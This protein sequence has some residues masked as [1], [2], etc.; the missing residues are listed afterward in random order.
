MHSDGCKCIDIRFGHSPDNPQKFSESEETSHGVSLSLTNV[1]NGQPVTP[2]DGEDAPL[3]PNKR[4]LKHSRSRSRD[5]LGKFFGNG[6]S[7]TPRASGDLLTPEK[8][9]DILKKMSDPET[10]IKLAPHIVK[11]KMLPNSFSGTE[12]CT[13]FNEYIASDPVM[14]STDPFAL[15]Q[16]LLSLGFI[17]AANNKDK[18]L[19]EAGNINYYTLRSK[20][21]ETDAKKPKKRRFL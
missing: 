18:S 21:T 9:Q 16:E 8:A 10:G 17:E 4:T 12:A 19:F 2:G 20:D 7:S 11:K 15:A 5:R 14:S 13:W 6:N 1:N 3:S